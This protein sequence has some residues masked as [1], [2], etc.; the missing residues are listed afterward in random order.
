MIKFSKFLFLLTLLLPIAACVDTE[1]DEPEVAF[2][3]PDDKIISIADVLAE[4]PGTGRVVLTD[5]ILGS[6]EVYVSGIVSADD[7][8]G[9]LFKVIYFQDETGA[10]QIEPDQNELNA[11]YPEGSIVYVKLNGLYLLRDS[12]VPK[13]AYAIDGN[14][15]VRTPDALVKTIMFSGGPADTPVVPEVVTLADVVNN[16]ALYFNKLVTIQGVELTEEFLGSSYA[17][18]D[19]IDGPETLN[20]MLQDCDGR[21]IIL[22][23]SGFSNFAGQIMPLGNGD[24]TCVV[25]KFSDDLQLFIRDT[26]DMALGGERCDGT[27]VTGEF[28]DNEISLADAKE[29]YLGLGVD[30]LPDGFIEGVVISDR[31]QGNI[32]NRNLVLQTDDSGIVLRFSQSHSYNLGE[33]LKV[34]VTGRS[35]STFNGLTQIDGISA[36]AIRQE[37][38][39]ELPEPVVVTASEMSNNI[40]DYES[41]RVTI[42]NATISGPVFEFNLDVTD[43]TGSIVT[44]IQSFAN[45]S[46]QATPT[47]TVSITGYGGLFNDP[48]ILINGPSDITG[49]G[50]STGGN[51]PDNEI[52]LADVKGN[53]LDMGVDAL[54]AGYIE[55]VVISD[56]SQGN[57]TNRNLVLQSSDAGIVLRFAAAHNY[58]L[59]EVL[60]VNVTG[61]S[62][63]TFNGLTQIDG[64]TES[65]IRQ[66][67]S[68]SLPE[69]VVVTASEMNSNI[70]DYESI[71][72]KIEDAT[73]SGPTYSFNLDVTDP[74][75]TIVT[76]IQSFATF[77]GEATPTGTV[78]IVGYGG[79]FN[80]PQILIN[81]PS[82]ITGGGGG[83]GNPGTSDVNQD[84]DGE[85]DFEPVDYEGWLNVTV[86]GQEPWYFRSFD[87]N[88]FAECEAF[89]ADGPETESWLVTP[90]IDTDATAIIEFETAQAF[91][92]HQG[93]SVWVSPNF[94]DFADANWTEITSARIANDSDGQ[95]DFVPSGEIDLKALVGGQ[96]RV[97]WKYEGTSA[98]NTTKVRIDNISIK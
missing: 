53:Y 83:G 23:N 78:D 31:A 52:S 1:F 98:A 88:G 76:F 65:L 19:G 28:P 49:G 26:D 51:F 10:L 32:T 24:V 13:L 29:Q 73:I 95:Y 90:T 58:Q 46:G 62:F 6:D 63:S 57:I 22:R 55:G 15:T 9:N 86:K 77:N 92:Q 82:D 45:F 87:D 48:Q 12:N 75:G 85:T 54:P 33:V 34:N 69:P 96:V 68:S 36:L 47:G 74:T 2:S 25:G 50:G 66:S 60:Q 81:G 20:V 11:A 71:R 72:V 21:E 4:L 14:F 84:F 7:E 56:A 59:G 64:L 93:L 43:A 89:Q 79:L 17:I 67:G 39:A 42:E 16:S 8:S 91:W 61:R 35:F 27:V 70:Y 18:A 5:S 44:F 97:G 80:D 94:T 38:M 41:I 37:G 3:V 30:K 40:Y